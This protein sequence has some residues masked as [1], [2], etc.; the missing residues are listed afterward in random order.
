MCSAYFV[1]S[2]LFVA[3][4]WNDRTDYV[5]TCIHNVQLFDSILNANNLNLNLNMNMNLK[6]AFVINAA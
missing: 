1:N 4:E 2:L 3:M 6:P 5:S